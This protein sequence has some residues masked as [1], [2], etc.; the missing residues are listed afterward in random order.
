MEPLPQMK[1]TARPEANTQP[2]SRYCFCRKGTAPPAPPKTLALGSANCSTGP[3]S[4]RAPVQFDANVKPVG[5][6]AGR[7]FSAS[8]QESTRMTPVVSAFPNK[9]VGDVCN[10]PENELP[11]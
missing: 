4:V 10:H 3:D 2:K 1:P 7:A 6:L 5:K 11:S 8:F 9:L